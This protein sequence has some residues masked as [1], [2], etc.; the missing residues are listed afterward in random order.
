MILIIQLVLFCNEL[1]GFDGYIFERRFKSNVAIFYA[2]EYLGG[3]DRR[4]LS[5]ICIF[6]G[7]F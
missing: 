1:D 5:I 4:F 6:A 3:V 7:L 2:K